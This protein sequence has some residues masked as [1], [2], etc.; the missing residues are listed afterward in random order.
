MVIEERTIS[1][2]GRPLFQRAK[3]ETPMKLSG[4]MEDMACFFYMVEGSYDV[5]DAHGAIQLGPQEA[6]LKRCGSY[7]SHLK[8]GSWDGIVIFFYPDVL[9]EIYKYEPP[10]FLETD[11]Q[12]IPPAKLAGNELVDKFIHGLFNYFDNPDLMDE[13]LALLKV[14][15]LILI[16]LKS[17]QYQHTRTFIADLF[18]P[19]RLHFTSVIEANL[20]SPLS[21]EEL[22]FICNKSLSSFKREFKRIY[23]SSPARYIK[24]RRLEHAAQQLRATQSPISDIAFNTGF[25]D[26]TT[27]S[28]SFRQKFSQSPTQYR[29]SQIG[30]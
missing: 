25:Q 8:A 20:F 13:E 2:Q 14:K 17:H 11:I 5:F 10:S 23:Q 7:V 24:E 16:L 26:L 30:K 12:P 15:E 9:H 1:F 21:L 6:L 19:E 18:T 22:A 28:A 3:F 29:M 4:K 27:F